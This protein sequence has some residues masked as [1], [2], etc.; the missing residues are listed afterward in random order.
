M[1]ALT[2]VGF[3]NYNNTALNQAETET[4]GL[5]FRPVWDAARRTIIYVEIRLAFRSVVYNL[6]YSSGVTIDDVMNALQG[7]LMQPC[8]SFLYKA[9]GGGTIQAN[10]PGSNIYDVMYG[11]QPQNLRFTDIRIYK[12]HYEWEVLLCLPIQCLN[13]AK[14]QFTGAA[15]WEFGAIPNALLDFNYKLDFAIDASGWTRRTYSGHYSVPATRIG[16]PSDKTIT[17]AADH[18]RNLIVPTPQSGFRRES[19]SYSLNEAK[20]REDFVIIDQ[21]MG[22]NYPPPGVIDVEASHT[23]ASLEQGL[24]RYSG[25]ISATYELMKGTSSA[26]AINHFMA[27]FFN[28]LNILWNFLSATVALGPDGKP[29]FAIIPATWTA[30]EPSIFGKVKCVFSRGYLISTSMQKDASK[31]FPGILLTTGLWE[32]SP[33]SNWAAWSASLGTGPFNPSGRGLADLNFTNAQDAIV[34][35]CLGPTLSTLRNATYDESEPT[36]SSPV[37]SNIYPPAG[38]S[39]LTYEN[40]IKIVSSSS[41]IIQTPLATSAIPAPTP[42]GGAGIQDNF[43]VTTDFNPASTTLGAIINQSGAQGTPVGGQQNAGP[44]SGPFPPTMVQQRSADQFWVI[45]TGRAVR[46]G[47]MINPPTLLSLGGIPCV[48]NNRLDDGFEQKVV[49]NIGFP[50]Y[51]ATWTFRYA[52]ASPPGVVPTADNPIYGG[53]DAQPGVNGG[54]QGNPAGNGNPANFVPPGVTIIPGG[55]GGVGGGFTTGGNPPPQPSAIPGSPVI[56]RGPY[57]DTAPGNEPY[58][59][60]PGAAAGTAVY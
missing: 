30:S 46:A 29:S 45:Q 2:A 53:G 57:S 54:A 38:A 7:V 5:S 4:T 26:V 32:P 13:G 19:Q 16:G 31:A 14:T 49:G 42:N 22:V 33:D 15:G 3:V 58:A 39:W 25:T 10:V 24:L 47:W 43:L 21:E 20:T 9:K 37:A 28:R 59:G 35:L 27:L 40:S 34:D 12:A 51:S 52:I 11:P 44:Q 1:S 56:P 60:F 23:Y 6:N 55:P 48:P 36:S 18:L 50:I 17:N 8:A 41:T